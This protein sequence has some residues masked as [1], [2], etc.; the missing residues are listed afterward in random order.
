MKKIMAIVLCV[1]CVFGCMSSVSASQT[2][3]AAGD[4]SDMIQCITYKDVDYQNFPSYYKLQ[5]LSLVGVMVPDVLGTWPG[6]MTSRTEALRLLY[7]ALGT[8]DAARA[9]GTNTMMREKMGLGDYGS[10]AWADGYYMAAYQDG[11]IAQREFDSA[12]SKNGAQAFRSAII[13][14]AEFTAMVDNALGE[15]GPLSN[16]SDSLTLTGVIE[17]LYDRYDRI[18][19]LRGIV[20]N[21]ATLQS[22][23]TQEAT[24][25]YLLSDDNVITTPKSDH[26]FDQDGTTLVIGK[27]GYDTMGVLVPGDDISYYVQGGRA[28]FI[29]RDQAKSDKNLSLRVMVKG[30]FFI[31]NPLSN[32][33]ILDNAMILREGKF[34]SLDSPQIVYLGAKST[35][36]AGTGLVSPMEMNA[37]LL[38]KEVYVVLTQRDVTAMPLANVVIAGIY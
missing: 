8:D 10:M 23:V 30:T 18:L 29:S 9:M 21:S 36:I 33:I 24:V 3:S 17:A 1:L 32:S 7:C 35:I 27:D 38:D 5:M 12:F 15:K 25:R 37:H 16:P 31:Y 11:L 4:I 13:K 14:N 20:K 28:I 26:P 2:F 22:I 34:T 19:Q 6:G